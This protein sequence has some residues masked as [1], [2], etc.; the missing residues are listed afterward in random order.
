MCV[1]STFI[2]QSFSAP[3]HDPQRVEKVL[4][5]PMSWI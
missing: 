2:Y 1:Y 3:L 4:H 5:R